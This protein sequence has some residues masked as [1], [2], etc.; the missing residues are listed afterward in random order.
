MITN[1]LTPRQLQVLTAIQ[2]SISERGFAPS[3]RELSRSLGCNKHTTYDHLNA[4][5]R[6][7]WIAKTSSF[8]ARNI[9]IVVRRD[10][11]NRPYLAVPIYN[12]GMSGKHALK[13][14]A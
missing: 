9:R 12:P 11:L 2:V 4:L 10:R 5:I 8:D 3:H 13:S 1:A 14:Y 6:K 7:G